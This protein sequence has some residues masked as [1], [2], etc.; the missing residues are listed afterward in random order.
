MAKMKKFESQL[1]GYSTQVTDSKQCAAEIL[2]APRLFPAIS[3]KIS[4]ARQI[5]GSNNIFS[6]LSASL[7][8]ILPAARSST[9]KIN[10]HHHIAKMIIPIRCFSCGKV[11]AQ[12][13]LTAP[14]QR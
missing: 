9:A 1:A 14:K 6:Y 2:A 11:G 12:I 10:I 3:D 8:A 5:L 7:E 4:T 13:P